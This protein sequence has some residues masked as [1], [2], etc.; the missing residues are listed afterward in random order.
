MSVAIPERVIVEARAENAKERVYRA[1]KSDIVSGVLD[2]GA[3]LNEGRLAAKYG[4]SKAPVREALVHLRQEGLVEAL[5]R[6]GYL[7]SRL[8][9]KDVDEIFELRAI[10]EGAA[11]EKAARVITDETLEKLEQPCSS[12]QP[13]DRQSYLRFMSDNFVFHFT[14]AQ[15]T[16]NSRLAEVVARQLEQMQRLAVLRLD[17]DENSEALADEHRQIVVALRQRDPQLARTLMVRSIDN[18]YQAAL[19]SLKKLMANWSI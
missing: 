5:P 1:L 9:M 4:V 17:L 15:A 12:F 7:T 19:L 16:G 8:T 10:V 2:M 6:V 3:M 14:I 11:A 13:G 18:T